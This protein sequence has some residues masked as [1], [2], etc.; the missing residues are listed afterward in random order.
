MYHSLAISHHNNTSLVD[1]EERNGQIFSDK[2]AA[3][4]LGGIT[5]GI[6]ILELTSAYSTIANGGLH[7]KPRFYTTVYDHDGL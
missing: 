4:S 7:Y 1:D 2:G 5:D 3:L 6:S